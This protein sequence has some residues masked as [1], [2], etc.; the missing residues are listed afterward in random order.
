[1]VIVMVKGSFHGHIPMHVHGHDHYL[2]VGFGGCVSIV[3]NTVS[4]SLPIRK[5]KSAEVWSLTIP[6]LT[7]SPT[8]HNFDLFIKIFSDLTG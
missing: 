8:N 7:S 6:P 2:C 3:C 1:M 5:V 4:V